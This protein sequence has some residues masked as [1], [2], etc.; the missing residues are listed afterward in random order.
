MLLSPLRNFVDICGV[1]DVRLDQVLGAVGTL[2]DVYSVVEVKFYLLRRLLG[3][4]TD[5][6][7]KKAKVQKLEKGELLNLNIGSRST[8]GRVTSAKK[9]VAKLE[10]YTPVC[11]KIVRRGLTTG[12]RVFPFRSR[13]A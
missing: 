12:R 5:G 7:T 8:G 3:V 13:I 4:K 2:P 1:F 11:T 10:L 9:G 6:D